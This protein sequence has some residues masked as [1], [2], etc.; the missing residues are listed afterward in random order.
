MALVLGAAIKIAGAGPN[1]RPDEGSRSN[2]TFGYGSDSCAAY[3][4]NAGATERA[5]LG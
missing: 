2:A 3:C 4:A 1:T 5:L